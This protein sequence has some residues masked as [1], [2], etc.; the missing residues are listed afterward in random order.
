M[1]VLL[2][3]SEVYPYSKTGGL[4]DMVAALA[5]SLAGAGAQV[6]VVTPL[7]RGIRDRFPEMQKLDWRM[8][9]PLGSRRVTAEIYQRKLGARLTFYFL[10][11]PGFYDRPELYQQNNQDYPDNPERFIFFA[12]AVAHMARYLPWRPEVVHA[13]D[14][15]AGLA[16]LLIR[17]QQKWEGWGTAPRTILTIHNLAYQ[18]NCPRPC[19][20]LTNLPWD[21]F[22]SEGVEFY[23]QVN[24]LKAAIEYA[25]QLTTVSPGYAR[26]ILTPALGAG[27][28]G[29]L[30]RRQ[31]VLTGILNGVDYAEWNTTRN[32]FLKH[33]FSV[34]NL[35]GK[36][37][38]K[39]DLQR[40]LGLTVSPAIPIYGNIGRLVE[41]KG[42]DILMGSLE[43]MLP[44]KMQ[45]VVLGSGLPQYEHAF[46]DLARRYPQQVAV[47]VGFDNGLP[48]RI[49][50]GC[51]YYLMP[52]RYEPC[53]L[54]QLY[55]LRYGA[56]PV[57][58]ATGGLN[59]T[60]ID[61]REDLDKANG[62][63][64]N[65]YSTAALSK[66][67]RKSLV[68]FREPD[69]LLHLRQNG[70]RANF[71]WKETSL[72]YLEIYRRARRSPTERAEGALPP[73]P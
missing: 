21:Y 41:Q 65:E 10:D 7:Y 19:Y 12:K 46:Q 69:L 40:E 23:G 54:N 68:L 50:A 51:D 28:D 60:V 62:I 49:K 30:K 4:A 58:R 52:S 44:S 31:A 33:H 38:E 42:I 73:T 25:D 17:H 70:M 35:A 64:F 59:D 3:S 57:V 22:N 1:R 8:D 43:E 24:L 13:H 53:G 15:Q 71:S 37:A 48:H 55:G 16:P 67:I 66:S 63:K 11:Q 36:A 27:L 5:K 2:A 56:V 72:Q 20:S 34:E 32:P 26:E 14:W 18:G 61:I 29:V 9:L 47:R 45:L 39:L 6:G